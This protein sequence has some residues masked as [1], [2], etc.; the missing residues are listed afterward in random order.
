MDPGVVIDIAGLGKDYGTFR[1]VSGLDLQVRPGERFALLGN[2]GAGKTT[3]IRMLM[4]ILRPSAGRAAV[5]G[6]DCFSERHL[7]M[8]H[9][10]YLPDEPVF[11][12][13]LRGSEILRF[14]AEMHG[15]ERAAGEARARALVA[16]L[17]LADATEE[18]A[19]NYSKGMK[20]KLSLAC[21]LLHRPRLLILDE[22]SNGLDPH[23]TRALLE[24]LREEAAGGTTV[25][26]STHLLDQAER[27]CSRIGIVSGGRL[28]EVGTLDELR[29]RHPGRGLEGIFFRVT[30]E[31]G[32]GGAAPASPDPPVG[33]PT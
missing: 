9:V 14:V 4:G 19:V 15:L 8:R 10:G 22:P 20:K 25:F 18:Y 3:T 30:G 28:A 29:A 6:Y 13:Y 21:A 5:C 12:D 11:Y 24:L 16:R 1:A 2:N 31:A 32:P 17:D 7:A 33:A 26:F 23:A 27:L